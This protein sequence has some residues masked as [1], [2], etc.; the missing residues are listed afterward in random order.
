MTV[1]ELLDYFA[2]KDPNA[3]VLMAGDYDYEITEII[4][5]HGAYVL[6]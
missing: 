5:D 2:D 1:K 6:A 4:E 3:E